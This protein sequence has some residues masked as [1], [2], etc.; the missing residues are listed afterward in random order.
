MTVPSQRPIDY[1]Y[2]FP[3][4]RLLRSFRIATDP[5]KLLLAAAA[6]TVFWLGDRALTLLPFDAR[7]SVA[8]ASPWNA[9]RP[10]LLLGWGT[11]TPTAWKA[12]IEESRTVAGRILS[13]LGPLLDVARLP[14]VRE[15]SWADLGFVWTRLFWALAVW[16][17]FGG[18]IARLA[19]VEFARDDRIGLIAALKFSVRRFGGFF[20][21]PLLPIGGVLLLW[22]VLAF[23][24]LLGRI[25]FVGE[26]LVAAFWGVAFVVALLIVLITIATAAGW[27]L[28]VAALG[29]EGS[30]AYDG[31][32]RAFSYLYSRPWLFVWCAGVALLLGL[33]LVAVVDTLA[34]GV[35]A[36]AARTVGTG[37]GQGAVA[38]LHAL[39][40]RYFAAV[41]TFPLGEA[42][43]NSAASRLVAVWLAAVAA[44]AVGFAVSYFWTAATMIYFLLRRADD[45]TPFDE[46]W[47][48]EAD[49]E[50]DLLPLAGIAS[51]DQPVTER[52]HHP[53]VGPPVA[54]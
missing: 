20:A 22:G 29:T 11:A 39:P 14:F 38:D 48:G 34:V 17:L 8:I 13:P 5:R 24:G 16:A 28:M 50:D 12:P 43:A 2:Y 1:A 54:T 32:S 52:P 40:P 30:D 4:T 35:A 45:A 53:T 25:P 31:F 10:T 3:W 9:V 51:T 44:V 23:G 26:W 46:V 49:E 27:P 15:Q 19:A 7:P 6:M 33:L 42:G 18:A 41:G 21:A 47:L 37:M 36:A